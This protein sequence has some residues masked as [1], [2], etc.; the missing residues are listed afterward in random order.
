[1]K[2]LKQDFNDS[3]GKY[4]SFLK[5]NKL[6]S[7]K[8]KFFYENNIEKMSNW[9]N[10]DFRK[11][12]R[13]YNKIRVSN[14]AVVRTIH[15]EK[16]KKWTYDRKKGVIKHNS[17]EF[18][19]IEGKRIG[20]SDREVSS[21][22]QPFIK[23]VGYKGGI[24][25]LVR[26]NIKGIPHYLIDAKYEPG[27]YNQIQ[28]SPSLQAT[29]SNL[30]RVH[31]GSKPKVVRKYFSKNYTTIRKF[32]V[33]ED[34]GRLYLKRNL[35]WIIQYNGRIDVPG[36]TFRWLTLWELDRFIKLGSLVGPH[37][38]SILSLI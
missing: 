35:H 9:T 16:M 15:L 38:R 10:V 34:G 4:I 6:Y 18:F 5:K 32:W 17:G 23:Q 24:I 22:D 14:K 11:T 29:Y 27:N 28:L 26:A 20:R 2:K 36:K 33:T 25:G 30:N 21:W 7:E 12:L 37:L 1:M 3:L 19:H 31:L 13:W 8:R